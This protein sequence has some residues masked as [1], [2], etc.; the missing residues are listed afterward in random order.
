L[1]IGKVYISK[2][3]GGEETSFQLLHNTD[4]D[5]NDKLSIISIVPLS[6]NQKKYLYMKIH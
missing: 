3:S 5:T 1:E 2:K 4:F 6:N